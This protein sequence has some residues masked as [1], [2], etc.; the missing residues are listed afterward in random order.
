ML[1]MKDLVFKEK[2]VKKLTK[3][4]IYSGGSN[5]KKYGEIETTSLYEN[6]AV[7][8]KRK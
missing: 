6:S 4:Y 2:P 8:N 1:S 7:D 5:I 3:R